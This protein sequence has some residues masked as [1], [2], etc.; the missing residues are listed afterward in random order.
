MTKQGDA[1]QVV[2]VAAGL[3]RTL[4]LSAEPGQRQR[5]LDVFIGRW[6]NEGDT[7]AT[8][9]L[10]SA[11]ILTSDVYEWAPGGF[12]VIHTAYGRIGDIEVGG[13]EIIGD[14]QTSD[15]YLSQFFDSRG[16]VSSSRLTVDDGVWTWLGERTRCT[17][18]FSEDGRVQTAHHERSDDRG[19]WTPT[20]DVTL[21]KIE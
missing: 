13:V 10:P 9:A 21:R 15:S 12:F 14:D 6:L 20:M 1:V 11:M 18:T 17:A 7:K 8:D 19:L 16:N 4:E 3:E 5:Q 2:S